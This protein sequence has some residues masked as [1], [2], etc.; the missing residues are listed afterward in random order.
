LISGA[1][2]DGDSFSIAPSSSQS[3]FATLANLIGALETAGGTPA[4]NAKLGSEIGF[5]LTNLDQSIDNILRVRA[6][7]GSRLNEIESLSSVNEDLNLQYQQTLSQLQ[8]L[9]YAKAISDLTRKQVDLQA[10]QQSFVKASQLSLFNY[11]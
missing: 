1:P 6:Q 9:D 2:A 11:L 10:A 8:D 5:A 4:G 7:L 3:I